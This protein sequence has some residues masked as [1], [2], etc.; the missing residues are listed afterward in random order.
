MIQ[1]HAAFPFRVWETIHHRHQGWKWLL[2][3]NSKEDR[4]VLITQEG[5]GLQPLCLRPV[6]SEA[7]TTGY[8]SFLTADLAV[9][10][11]YGQNV[12]GS[13]VRARDDAPGTWSTAVCRVLFRELKFVTLPQERISILAS[14]RQRWSLLASYFNAVLSVVV[15]RGRP[16]KAGRHI[17]SVFMK[18]KYAL[19]VGSEVMSSK[20]CQGFETMGW[21]L[22]CIR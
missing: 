3:F 8:H 7:T 1:I 10:N 20:D 16:R 21:Y 18:A 15:I 9:V 6:L 14:K 13:E 11:Q 2:G 12:P 22:G 4:L 19:W 17:Q 5:K